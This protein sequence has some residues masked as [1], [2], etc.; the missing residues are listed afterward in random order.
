MM[1]VI[2]FLLISCEEKEAWSDVDFDFTIHD[3]RVQD[4][5]YPRNSKLKRVYQVYSDGSRLQTPEKEYTYDKWDRVSRVDYDY[6][7]YK[8]LPLSWNDGTPYPIDEVLEH[9]VLYQYNEKGLLEKES[10]YYIVTFDNLPNLRQSVSY[11]YDEKGNKVKEEI[12]DSDYCQIISYFYDNNGNIIKEQREASKGLGSVAYDLYQY[13]AERPVRKDSYI[14]EHLQCYTLYEYTGNMHEKRISFTSLPK[15]FNYNS[16]TELFYEQNLLVY[17]VK[18]NK[19]FGVV[20]YE[21]RRYYDQNDNI[22]KTILYRPGESRPG[23]TTDYTTFE[24]EYE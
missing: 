16:T 18:Y 3:H 21:E 6:E 13:D 17:S 14:D 20:A 9:Y 8:D 12:S 7:A 5:L 4:V 22:V 2:S 19:K 15:Y 1:F 11:L 24:Y 10:F 23:F